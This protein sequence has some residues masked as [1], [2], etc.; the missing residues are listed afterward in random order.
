MTSQTQVLTV[1]LAYHKAADPLTTHTPRD[2]DDITRFLAGITSM[3]T[4]L[5]VL[6]VTAI[7]RAVSVDLAQMAVQHLALACK[8]LTLVT[9]TDSPSHSRS[10]GPCNIPASLH[11]LFAA[12]PHPTVS[13]KAMTRR[14]V[15]NQVLMP[16]YR[17]PTKSE[18]MDAFS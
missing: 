4:R 14:S 3:C 16:S 1:D 6:K 2:S 17:L 15:M 9:A 8:E 10:S 13:P 12:A 5:R 7:R 11:F 18:L